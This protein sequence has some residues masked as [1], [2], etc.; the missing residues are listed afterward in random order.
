MISELALAFVLATS[1]GLMAKSLLK[2]QQVDPG[3]QAER[4]LSLRVSPPTTR[5][6][7][8]TRL[9]TYWRVALERV[10]SV[11]GVIE[12]GAIHLTPMG[13]NNWNPDL[14]VEGALAPRAGESRSVDWRVVTPEYFRTMGIPL[15][16][17][18]GFTEQDRY[19]TSVVAIVNRT[20][21]RA[22][23]GSEDPIGKRVRTAFDGRGWATIVGEVGDV[24][25]HGLAA[26]PVPELYRPYAQSAMESMTLMIRGTGD[27]TNLVASVRHALTELDPTVIL[28]EVHPMRE[29]VADSIA[30]SSRL[31]WL[32]L[33]VGALALTLAATGVFGVVA[34]AV[35]SRTRELGIRVALGASGRAIMTLVLRQGVVLTGAGLVVGSLLA[36]GTVGAVRSQ[37]YEVP[38]H[39][40]VVYILAAGT[41]LLVVLLATYVPA[42]RATRV[43]PMIALRNE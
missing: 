6:S 43:D 41:L 11:P 31:T 36:V 5:Y 3:F 42:R 4:V 33:G 25:G 30:G 40:P 37:L 2:L 26:D 39:D 32:L 24:H 17:G 18:R 13:S 15:L 29:V 19:G 8:S 35:A 28:D 34:F 22:Y 27:P 9:L 38:P 23:F 1:A 21:A 20:L 10:R 16:R 14:S 12:T 7:D